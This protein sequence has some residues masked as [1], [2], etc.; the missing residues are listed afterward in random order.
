MLTTPAPALLLGSCLAQVLLANCHLMMSWLNQLEKIIETLK[1][2]KPKPGFR[3]WLSS[4]PHPKFPI[5]ERPLARMTRPA[6]ALA[7]CRRELW[8]ATPRG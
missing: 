4:S 2:R 1:E 5:G 3:L 7:A 8:R 6:H